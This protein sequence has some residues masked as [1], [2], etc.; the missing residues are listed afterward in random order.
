MTLR[1][2]QSP[3]LVGVMLIVSLSLTWLS[4]HYLWGAVPL[5]GV[6][7]TTLECFGCDLPEGETNGVTRAIIVSGGQ[8]IYVDGSTIYLTAQAQSHS[9]FI[10]CNYGLRTDCVLLSNHWAQFEV[11]Q[12][13]MTWTPTKVHVRGYGTN[14]TFYAPF[15]S[16]FQW[17][18]VKFTPV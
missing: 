2:S 15:D 8:D 14:Y 5:P 9:L 18:R 11:S 3:K 17:F 12:N 7:R 4:T 10:L 1:P 13:L 6:L 16:Q